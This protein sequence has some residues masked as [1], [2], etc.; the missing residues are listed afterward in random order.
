[1]QKLRFLAIA[2]AAAFGLALSA[3]QPARAA[4]LFICDL[5]I[6]GD[7]GP[8]VVFA[9]GDFDVGFAVNGALVQAG[10]GSS[11]SLPVDEGSAA[12]LI[13]GAGVYLFSG[14]WADSGAT[15]PTD[16]TI[17]FIDPNDP[18]QNGTTAVSTVL[19]YVYAT[20]GSLGHLDGYVIS[21][22]GRRRHQPRRHRRC[23][24]HSHSSCC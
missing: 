10:L 24:H 4:A 7:P 8:F 13:D 6:C 5:P 23:R 14:L 11:A 22:S 12:G 18:A 15:T 21:D 19:H 20:D 3:V 9:A 2:A 16:Q 17:L 1:M